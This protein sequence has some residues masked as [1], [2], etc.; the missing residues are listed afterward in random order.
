MTM[1]Y[2]S[3]KALGDHRFR[4]IRGLKKIFVDIFFA[5]QNI[6][7]A[8]FFSEPLEHE[9]S[10]KYRFSMCLKPA[11]HRSIHIFGLKS[12]FFGK[13]IW[14]PSVNYLMKKSKKWSKIIQMWID[15]QDEDSEHTQNLYSYE[16][17]GPCGIGKNYRGPFSSFILKKSTNI[18]FIAR[19]VRDPVIT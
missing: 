12:T 6:E 15:R 1:I 8:Y 17:L 5:R 9:L 16:S 4:T 13:M 11:T 3:R 10:P 2:I 7:P 19:F 14:N 18:F